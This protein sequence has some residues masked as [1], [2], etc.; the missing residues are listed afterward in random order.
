[1]RRPL[2]IKGNAKHVA[3]SGLKY[4]HAS[5]LV[6]YCQMDVFNWLTFY[7]SPP[8]FPFYNTKAHAKAVAKKASVSA[9]CA[10]AAA[11]LFGVY[12]G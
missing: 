12:V 9:P 6:T 3:V 8:P 7:P 2:P 5:Y 4:F 11:L 10:M 1:M